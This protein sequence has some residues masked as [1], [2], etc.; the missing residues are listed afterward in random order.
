MRALKLIEGLQRE[1]LH[2]SSR[3]EFFDGYEQ[4]LSRW[5]CTKCRSF[6]KRVF[7]TGLPFEE[8]DAYFVCWFAGGPT[9]L[10]GA[11]AVCPKAR[12]RQSSVSKS[13]SGRRGRLHCVHTA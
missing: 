8:L 12:K 9:D 7:K 10:L 5:G 3:E 2:V 1:G 4:R 6:E 11:G 13:E